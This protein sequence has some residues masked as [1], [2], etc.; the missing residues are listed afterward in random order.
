MA[1]ITVYNPLLMNLVSQSGV[2]LLAV[3][4]RPAPE[5]STHHLSSRLSPLSYPDLSP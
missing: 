1:N 2:P 3:E 5:V 4:F